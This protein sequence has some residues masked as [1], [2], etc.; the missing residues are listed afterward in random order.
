MQFP[1]E[2]HDRG[3][4]RRAG[5][6]T[7]RL[8]GLAIAAAGRDLPSA[9]GVLR[10]LAAG[11]RWA[12]LT[13]PVAVTGGVLTVALVGWRRR[14]RSARC[15]RSSRCS[16]SP[17]V[18]ACCSS[19]AMR[20]LELDGGESFGPALVAAWGTA[21][22]GADPGDG[23][24]DRAGAPAL[25]GHGRDRGLRD[26]S[27]DGGRHAGRSRHVD[28][29]SPVRRPDRLPAVRRQRGCRTEVAPATEAM[30]D[31]TRPCR[32]RQSGRRGHAA[33]TS[34]RSRAH[35]QNA[36][37]SSTW[38]K[39]RCVIGFHGSSRLRWS[40]TAA[41]RVRGRFQ[42][43]PTRRRAG[44]PRSRRSRARSISRIT[45]TQKAMERL[46]VQTAAVETTGGARP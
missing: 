11:D 39:R 5:Q 44:P 26:R 12:S 46:G 10:E 45:L 18:T 15:W 40:S 43:A 27:P 42:P 22:A 7:G 20:R 24:G 25:R 34:S 17:C 19:S 3:S 9:A 8:I 4:R 14:S 37:K 6:P 2:Y 13:F 30:A 29:C 36:A 41:R 16:G 1:L 33:E 21:N 23:A 28:A 35:E 38:R 31:R 32:A